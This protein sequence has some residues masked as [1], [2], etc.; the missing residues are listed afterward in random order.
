MDNKLTEPVEPSKLSKT[1]SKAKA[2]AKV[3]APVETKTELPPKKETKLN[4]CIVCFGKLKIDIMMHKS[5]KSFIESKFLSKQDFDSKV[6]GNIV[7][8]YCGTCGLMYNALY[9]K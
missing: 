4:E 9:L 5:G 3:K 8:T 2:K 6:K 7:K 1:K